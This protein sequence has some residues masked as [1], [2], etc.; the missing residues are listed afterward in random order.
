[1]STNYNLAA[2]RELL[3]AAF[4]IGEINNP[5]FDL[6]RAVY[7][8]FSGGMSKS[9]RIRLVVDAA[10]RHGRLPD[11]LAYVEKENPYQYGRFAPNLISPESPQMNNPLRAQRLAAIQAR[12][13]DNYDLLQQ[14]EKQ[15]DVENDPRRITRIKREIE[16]QRDTIKGYESEAAELG[17]ASDQPAPP[18][19]DAAA[20]AVQTGL[21]DLHAKID[22]LSQQLTGA[23]SRLAAGQTVIRQDIAAQRQAIIDRVDLRYA[24]TIQ[25]VTDQ[26]QGEQLQIVGLLVT[27]VDQN[28]IAQAEAQQIVQ[29][30]H[31]ALR[32]LQATQP[33]AGD[34]QNM[35]RL[36][37]QN[38]GWE[39]KLKLTVPLIPYLLTYE[40]E[41]KA[42]SLGALKQAWGHLTAALS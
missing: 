25:R 42:D 19:N 28:R 21:T 26:L 24:Q 8:D 17:A 14:Y 18:A 38:T 6:F 1:M 12:L 36:L 13:N 33:D 32:S 20:Q 40:N 41:I 37:E 5:A 22:S 39:Q 3:T 27:A 34:W 2:V 4:T 11:L 31:N 23:E 9:E 35:L 16:R 15:L 29:L 7:D 30:T 10:V